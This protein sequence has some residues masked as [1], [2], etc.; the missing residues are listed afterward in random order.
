M[1][2]AF[3]THWTMRYLAYPLGAVY[4]ASF[5]FA[6]WISDD[7]LFPIGNGRHAHYQDSEAYLK[8]TAADGKK[9]TARYL[10]NHGMPYTI[11][12]SH[13]NGEDLGDADALLR[14]LHDSGFSVFAYDYHGYGTSEGKASER[15]LYV[16]IDAAYAYLTGPLAIPPERIILLGFSLGSGP[17]VDLAARKPV[18]GLILQ[19]AFTSAYRTMTRYPIFL[20]DKFRN[21]AKMEQVRCPVLIIHG[22]NDRNISFYHG[23]TLYRVAHEPKRC[24]WVDG[25]GHN[26]LPD[27]AGDAYRKAL[28]EFARLIDSSRAPSHR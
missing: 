22:R 12:Y 7:L 15:A 10:P 8:L 1:V 21:L 27:A 14:T 9:I 6:L 16:D 20:C 17:S 19:S 4:F 13:G 23:Q 24:L 3:L 26:N 11:L 2:T 28:Q 25:A 18:A 5:L